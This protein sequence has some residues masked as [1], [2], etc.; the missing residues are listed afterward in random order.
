VVGFT[1]T[2]DRIQ[3]KCLVG[4]RRNRWSDSTETGDR[5]HPKSAADLADWR[6]ETLAVLRK[7]IRDTDP[8]VIEEWKGMGSPV[9]SHGGQI[10]VAS[11]QK[12]KVKLT[13]AQGANLPDPHRFFNAG[14]EG[15]RWRAIDLHEG[16]E[17][18]ERALQEM[19]HAAVAFNGARASRAQSRNA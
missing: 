1:E 5:F 16:D 8:E 4:F 12:D 2:G 15:N 19:V 9:W 6:G 14:L 10:A 11:A 3:P 18:D 17:V 7:A 13:F